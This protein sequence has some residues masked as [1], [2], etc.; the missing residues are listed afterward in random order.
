MTSTIVFIYADKKIE[1]IMNH[2]FD[3]LLVQGSV[4]G[5]QFSSFPLCF[6]PLVL[7][8]QPQQGHLIPWYLM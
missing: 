1:G 7:S 8:T 3:F 4:L 2:N 5:L 6:L